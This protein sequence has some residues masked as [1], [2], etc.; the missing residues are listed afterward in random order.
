MVGESGGM[1]DGYR[2]R[3]GRLIG[4]TGGGCE[5]RLREDV[6]IEMKMKMKMK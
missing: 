4:G 3:G 1:G 6:G 2:S 5:G